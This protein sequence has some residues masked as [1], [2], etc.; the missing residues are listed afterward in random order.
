VA[1]VNGWGP[2]ELD[3]SVGEAGVGDGGPLR[4]NGVT[5]AKGLGTHAAADIRY[6]IPADCTLSAQV[7]IDDE[8]TS[9]SASVVFEV[10]N[11]TATRVYQSPVKGA[12]DAA[13]AVSVLLGG[14]TSLRLVVDPAGDGVSYDHA[15]WGDAKIICGSAS[16]GGPTPTISS[17]TT[18]QSFKV[19]D[20]VQ[21]SGSAT[22]AAGQPIP[23]SG[24]SWQVVLHHCPG[25]DCHQHPFATFTGPTASFE[26][27]DHGDDSH[28]EIKL[29]ATDSAGGTATVA[30][31]MQPQTVSLTLDTTPT[32][33][34]LIYGGAVLTAPATVQ[35]IVGGTRTIEAPSPQGNLVWQSWSDGG[36]RQHA[37]TVPAASATFRAA[38]A[39]TSGATTTYLSDL[40]PSVTAVNGWGPVERD[41]SVGEAGVGDGGPLRINGVTYTKGL[42]THAAADIRYTIPSNCTLSA[43]V[44]IDDEVTS[45]S[46]SVA[47]EVWNG[48][49]TRMYRSP[50]K[51]AVDAATEVS[52]PLSG[53]TNLRLVVDPS[54]SVNYDHA[55]W[56]D[57]KIICAP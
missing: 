37:I 30:R 36:A 16:T 32:G 31:N 41:Q 25:G 26:A 24:L 55:D 8:V 53:V 56:G 10:W 39:P 34:Q 5:Y 15:D 35:A 3:Q 33:L 51:R 17:P 49:T 7:G 43:Q 1:P 42:G 9:S 2:V 6:T 38:F 54:G 50:V 19:G 29:T 23:N 28:I 21:L 46:A 27:P 47:F 20:V 57:A 44:G 22:D 11:G 45:S 12:V 40:S 13:T 18:S 14:V 4:I 52:V 48:T